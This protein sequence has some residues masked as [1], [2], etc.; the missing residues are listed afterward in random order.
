ME[1]PYS[2][3]HVPLM[4][5]LLRNEYQNTDLSLQTS[6]VSIFRGNADV[7]AIEPHGLVNHNLRNIAKKIYQNT[8][9]HTKFQKLTR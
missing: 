6:K 8:V 7:S 2:F 5:Y 3:L 9:W 1:Q 4:Y